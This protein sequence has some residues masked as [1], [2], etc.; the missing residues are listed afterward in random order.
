MPPAFIDAKGGITSDMLTPAALVANDK[1]SAGG[2]WGR[3]GLWL[4]DMNKIRSLAVLIALGVLG[5]TSVCVQA[6]SEEGVA[7]AIV[8][9]TSG[10]MRDPVKDSAGKDTPKYI[11]A[12]RALV[13]ITKQLQT[14]ASNSA[15]ATRKIETGLY[16][17]NRGTARAVVPFG[18]FDAQAIQR[19][20]AGF[21]KPGGDTPLGNALN[22]AGQAVLKSPLSHKHV[23]II[24][25]GMNTTGP[26]P[27]AILP[28][29]QQQAGGKEAISVHFIAFDVAAKQFDDVRQ[30]GATVVAAADEGQLFTQVNYILQR[31]ILLEDEE[32]KK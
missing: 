12:N 24:T 9:D 19:W 3:E 11:I 27:G 5:L 7:L 10:S 22:V 2:G 4:V 8:Y 15:G 32:P 17:F 30:Q 25:D 28:Q 21:S 16:T 23:L 26:T 13:S 31:K 18:P 20:V 6:A 1:A 14:F 29:L